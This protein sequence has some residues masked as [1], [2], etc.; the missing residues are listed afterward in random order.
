MLTPSS[1]LKDQLHTLVE[2]EEEEDHDLSAHSSRLRESSNGKL[3]V[4]TITKGRCL[5]PA[6]RQNVNVLTNIPPPD[7]SSNSSHPILPPRP[8]PANLSLRPLTLAPAPSSSGLLSPAVSPNIRPLALKTLTLNASDP[9]TSNVLFLSA[10]HKPSETEP[11]EVASPPKPTMKVNRHPSQE[12]LGNAPYIRSAAVA[13]PVFSYGNSALPTPGST[14]TSEK[15]VSSSSTTTSESDSL[16]G[17]DRRSFSDEIFMH[18]SHIALLARITDLERALHARSL[19]TVQSSRP[20]PSDEMLALIADLKLERDDLKQDITGY[21]VRVKELEEGKGQLEQAITVERSRIKAKEE[22]AAR[23]E[24]E[25]S[26]LIRQLKEKQEELKTLLSKLSGLQ[27][28]LTEVERTRDESRNETRRLQQQLEEAEVALQSKKVLED[29]LLRARAALVH[30]QSKREQ[31]ERQ[32]SETSRSGENSQV[33]PVAN[34]AT[35]GLGFQSV[36]S[37]RTRVGSLDNQQMVK[38]PFTLKPV[39]EE[40][41]ENERSYSDEENGLAGYE[42]EDS[43]MS[44]TCQSRSL[45]SSSL[46]D[47]MPRSVQH[48][49]V[50]A[51]NL[52][53]SSSPSPSPSPCPTPRSF[54]GD[55]E[56]A[57]KSHERRASLS[58]AW[59]FPT[60]DQAP[61]PRRE[62]VDHFFECLD[63]MDDS[64]PLSSIRAFSDKNAFSEALRKSEEEDFIALPPIDMSARK[65]DHRSLLEVVMEAEEDDYADED[66]QSVEL[67]STIREGLGFGK[68]RSSFPISV[69]DDSLSLSSHGH[70]QESSGNSSLA[71]ITPFSSN[72]NGF[73]SPTMRMM[74]PQSPMTMSA[75]THNFGTPRSNARALDFNSSAR[76]SENSSPTSGRI[77]TPREPCIPQLASRSSPILPIKLPPPPPAKIPRASPRQTPSP[78]VTFIAAPTARAPATPPKCLESSK[79]SP[80]RTYSNGSTLIPQLKLSSTDSFLFFTVR[81]YRRF[82]K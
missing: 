42:D 32:I 59:K 62:E 70:S 54:P 52:S 6:G 49:Q 29:E 82:I 1:S 2:E 48:L 67:G 41:D 8:K 65:G 19:Q 27:A 9:P 56:S 16:T 38:G 33:L 78:G 31:L 63:D 37:T 55:T 4:P 5:P 24:T 12:R 51:Q 60:G 43:D 79:K 13:V 20:E 18:Q 72:A 15:R 71:A 53:S 21:R 68:G 57:N 35:R 66:A 80:S 61:T 30:E 64:P 47:E 77:M 69:S 50:A 81:R 36:D 11:S 17:R 40:E 73:G 14:P 26:M 23:L 34:G 75:S 58:K 3:A 74:L 7:R 28:Q 10:S 22:K 44:F 39:E 25:K 76:V 45:S 46:E